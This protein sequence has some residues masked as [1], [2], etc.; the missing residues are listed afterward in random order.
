MDLITSRK[1]FFKEVEGQFVSASAIEFQE[2]SK[3]LAQEAAQ[4]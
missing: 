2:Y 3:E 1:V 4:Y